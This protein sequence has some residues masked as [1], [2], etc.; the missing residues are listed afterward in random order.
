MRS[1]TAIL[2]PAAVATALMVVSC[3][4]GPQAPEK[5]TPAFYWSAARETFS[6]ADYIAADDNLSKLLKTGNEFV[7]RA[8]PWGLVLSSGIAKGYSELADNFEHGA[9]ARKAD[10]AAFRKQTSDQRTLASQYALE[11]AEMF[12]R[13]A[14]NNQDQTITLD[15]PF[16]TGSVAPIPEALKISAG[17]AAQPADIEKAQN[18][19]L[20][21]AVLLATCL[22]AG[23]PDDTAKAQEMFKAGNVQV[24]RQVFMLAMAKSLYELG[25]LY[26]PMKLDKPDKQ[27]IFWTTAITALEAVPQSKDAK[28]L[29]TKIQTALKKKI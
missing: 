7:P 24:P 27:K 2:F 26:G 29:N 17:V 6:T 8:L 20:Q 28:Q 3:S 12:Q 23:A 4:T 16:P 10:P 14:K 19:S 18:R 25:G 15:F 13:F 5:G 11:F 22:A 9:R 21:K 1:K